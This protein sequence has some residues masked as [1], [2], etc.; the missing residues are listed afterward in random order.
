MVGPFTAIVKSIFPFGFCFGLFSSGE[1]SSS[2]LQWALDLHF[3][4]CSATSCV[5]CSKSQTNGCDYQ[6]PKMLSDWAIEQS[7]V[8][9]MQHLKT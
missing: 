2:D 4:Q 3:K 6:L 7:M 8:I 5:V 9:I 1:C